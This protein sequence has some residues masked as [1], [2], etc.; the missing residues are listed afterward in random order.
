MMPF[1]LKYVKYLISLKTKGS[2]MIKFKEI[3][4]TKMLMSYHQLIKRSLIT[5]MFSIAMNIPYGK[6]YSLVHVSIVSFNQVQFLHLY[7]PF[8]ILAF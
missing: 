2:T 7:L 6:L 5:L 3:T 8:M 4:L 1:F